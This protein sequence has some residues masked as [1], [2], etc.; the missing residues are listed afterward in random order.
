VDDIR[1]EFE[2][3]LKDFR[4]EVEQ[5]YVLRVEFDPVKALVFGFVGLAMTGLV[6]AVLALVI[7]SR[8]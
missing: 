5:K 7:R 2:R 4:A 1:A 3:K 6:I 8:S